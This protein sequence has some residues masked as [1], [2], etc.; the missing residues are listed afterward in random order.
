MSSIIVHE[1]TSSL[2]I[3]G[4]FLTFNLGVDECE[5]DPCMHNATC[6][7]GFQSYSCTCLP[8]YNGTNCE[9]GK[10]TKIWI[11]IVIYNTSN[12]QR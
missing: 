7:D 4:V 10:Y 9:I 12:R 8:G 11:K 5:S 3:N 6:V 1:W 2:S